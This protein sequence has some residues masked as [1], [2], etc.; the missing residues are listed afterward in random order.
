MASISYPGLLLLSCV[1]LFTLD[2]KFPVTCCFLF[3]ALKAMIFDDY[4]ASKTQEFNKKFFFSWFQ[5]SICDLLLYIYMWQATSSYLD[6][7][8]EDESWKKIHRQPRNNCYKFIWWWQITIRSSTLIICSQPTDMSNTKLSSGKSFS[9][10][11]VCYSLLILPL[12]LKWRRFH[13]GKEF[14]Q[15]IFVILCWSKRSVFWLQTN[16]LLQWAILTLHLFWSAVPDVI[17]LLFFRRR[18][19]HLQ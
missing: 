17:R 2:F 18:S 5:C 14:P 11:K 3:K 19:F 7:C 12:F 15:S 10:W 9:V 6:E 8:P 16:M 1:Y 13:S 4:Q